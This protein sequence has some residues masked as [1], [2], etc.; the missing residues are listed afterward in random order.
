MTG[1]RDRTASVT[2]SSGCRMPARS[3]DVAALRR[4]AEA[5][6]AA[7]ARAATVRPDASCGCRQLKCAAHEGTRV[8]CA[9]GVVLALR[10]DPAVGQ[11]WTLM[12][13]CSACAPHMSHTRVVARAAP[14]A[15]QGGDAPPADRTAP[16]TAPAPPAQAQ[17]ARAVPG[18]FSAPP[19]EPGDL[20]E[21]VPR[22]RRGRQGGGGRS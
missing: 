15:R 7:H 13:V 8:S 10:H 22:R 12:E 16:Q 6:A 4:F 9:G 19:R 2:C 18:G 3:R 14:R 11:V 5:H 20:Q 1:H 17:A 21:E